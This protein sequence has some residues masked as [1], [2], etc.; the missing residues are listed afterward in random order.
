MPR[1][2]A[3]V[4]V[5]GGG[6]AG[7]AAALSA[8]LGGA[9]VEIQEKSRFP[10][11]KVCGEFVSPEVFPL[12]EDLGVAVAFLDAR[13]ARIRRL[14]LCFGGRE[15]T[16]VLPEP[17]Y[18]LSRF[19]FDQLLFDSACR[20]GAVPLIRA[21]VPSGL[22]VI[23]NGRRAAAPGIARGRRLFGF[24]SHFRG[25]AND[26]IELHFFDRGY[27][28]ISAVE[29]GLTNVCGLASEA[30]LGRMG[31]EYDAL[32]EMVPS[33]RERLAPLERAM[34]WLTTGPL[35]FGNRFRE[36]PPLDTYYS[37]DALAFVDPF[38]GSGMYSAVLTGRIA[39]ASVAEGI[40][41]EEH[42]RRCRRALGRGLAVSRL[43]R[44]A[45]TAGCARHF[46]R[47]LPARW[48]Y[49]ATRP[50]SV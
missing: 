38:T 1:R 45:V 49:Y 14:R 31:F 26:T 4:T 27:L 22:R 8:I 12:L 3:Q 39:G 48:L 33:V 17:A 7:S 23:A 36:V 9:S 34:G 42:L 19:V 16:A 37:G 41:P 25:P 47:F 11:H 24:K 20:A 10:R 13:P 18:G 50:R 44:S 43:F 46:A 2:Q 32:L 6:P 30:A 35:I 29:G 28:G 5:V 21:G 40:A 15:T